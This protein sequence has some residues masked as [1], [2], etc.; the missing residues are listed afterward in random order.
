MQIIQF[1]HKTAAN[2]LKK[3]V[4]EYW[5]DDNR[6]AYVR[7]TDGS[8]VCIHPLFNSWEVYVLLGERKNPDSDRSFTD[9]TDNYI[10]CRACGD[11]PYMSRI[12]AIEFDTVRYYC[13]Y[14]TVDVTRQYIPVVEFQYYEK[15]E[16]IANH[17]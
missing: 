2:L 1:N 10:F 7:F 16:T 3:S 15:G 13:H 9:S 11:S 5:L 17:D 4:E 14:G 8:V 6:D 12:V